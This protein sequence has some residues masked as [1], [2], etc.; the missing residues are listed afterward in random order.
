VISTRKK[1]KAAFALAALAFSGCASAAA[2]PSA[3]PAAVRAARRGDPAGATPIQH[4]VIVMQENR[5]FDNLF[6]GFPGADSANAGYGHGKRY[7]MKPWSMTSL[8]DIN[9][10][11]YQFLEDY[12]GGKNDGFDVAVT[13]FKGGKGCAYPRVM[14]LPKCWTLSPPSNAGFAYGYVPRS[15]IQPYWTMA[16]QYALGD[17]TFASN[18]GPSYVSHEF[19]IAGQAAHVVE[20]PQL[21]S[22]QKNS[23]GPWGCNAVTFDEFTIRVRYAAHPPTFGV[24]NGLEVEGPFPCF[25]Y[26]TAADLLDAA[27]VSWAY[28]APQIGAD[29]GD[30]WSAFDAIWPVR[31]GADWVND[32]KSPE[33][34]VLADIQSGNL[35]QVSWVVPSFVNSD[36]AG[37]ASDTG[38]QWVA[39]IV[40]AIGNSPYWGN[41]AIVVM[42]DDWGG[43]YDHVPPPQ[44]R[45][46]QTR[47][48]EGLG[49]R[50][51]LIVISPYAK[52]GYVSH[53]Q[54]EIASSLHFIENVFG[55]PSLGAADARA[56]ALDDMFDFTQ[57]PAPFQPIPARMKAADFMRQAPSTRPPD[58][59]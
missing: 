57:T 11:H 34:R 43:W 37:S 13:G 58:D 53:A 7:A 36:H 1:M 42:W 41:T 12:D 31:F 30:I 38:P 18:S 49:F 2:P 15:E 28:Y 40:N 19:M 17:R 44:Y 29:R 47:V 46:P 24:Q 45:D 9:H 6:H 27:H 25:T 4:V 23:N 52:H 56:D 16:S 59:D 54:H 21:H 3:M 39:A 14:N 26:R 10:G 22:T 55:L 5:S 35:P 48:D 51:P 50:V 8:G 32:V 33:N 20:N